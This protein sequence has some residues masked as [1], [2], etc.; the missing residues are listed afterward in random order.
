MKI[1]SPHWDD[2]LGV[3]TKHGVPGLPCPA[4]LAGEGD[5]DLEFVVDEIDLDVLDA[6][7][8]LGCATSLRDLVPANVTNPVFVRGR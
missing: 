2:V 4:C 5:E 3:C 6:E 7:R 8:A 1:I